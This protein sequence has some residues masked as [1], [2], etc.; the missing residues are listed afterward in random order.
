MKENQQYSGGNAIYSDDGIYRLFEV[1]S[2]EGEKW[3]DESNIGLSS[4]ILPSEKNLG[5]RQAKLLYDSRPVY[6]SIFQ[7][8]IRDVY[9]QLDQP[10]YTDFSYESNIGSPFGFS[11][12]NGIVR[13]EHIWM[14]EIR[15]TYGL[16]HNTKKLHQDKIDSEFP[17][18]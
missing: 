6:W 14:R 3:N 11:Q 12:A 4:K 18:L 2:P 13:H 16:W 15:Q 5:V 10:N 9:Y 17:K 8:S 1:Q 7:Q